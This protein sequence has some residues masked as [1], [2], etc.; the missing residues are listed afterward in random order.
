MRSK[1]QDKHY[2]L[3]KKPI[4]TV[5]GALQQDIAQGINIIPQDVYVFGI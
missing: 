1:T 3:F 2:K 5:I 4:L